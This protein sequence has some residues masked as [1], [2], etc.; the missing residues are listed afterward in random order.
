MKFDYDNV[1]ITGSNGWLGKKLIE[2]FFIE[3]SECIVFKKKDSLKVNC[4]I[5]PDESDNFI[6]S[7]SK[8]IR[9][10]AGDI[11]NKDDCYDFLEASTGDNI[12]IHAAG[13]IHPKKV[14][15]FFKVNL[16]G[17]KN[18][19]NEALN[20]KFKKIIVVSSNS[21][22]GCNKNNTESFNEKSPYNPYMN[23]GKS[24]MLMENFLNKKI[25]DGHDITI[26]RPPWFYG[27]NMPERQITFYNM[28]IS[29]KFPFVGDGKNVRSI[30]NVKN[31]VQ[32]IILSAIINKSKGQTYWIADK[33]NLSMNQIVKT[34]QEV[35][36]NEFDIKCKKNN[37]YLPHFVGQIAELIDYTL[38]KLGLYH[39]KFHVLS[40]MNK[41]IACDIKKAE[42]EL[43][44]MPKISLYQGTKIAYEKYLKSNGS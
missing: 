40:E 39:Q 11:V 21:P 42:D 9:V 31:I 23:Y 30:A 14:Q 2:S 27:E 41:N 1:Y 25:L 15:D 28:I 8:D 29:G 16:E 38:Q 43:G 24:K 17:T 32:G 12:L 13:L 18:I 37:I 34:I 33:D 44:Y 5:T 35:F 19:V 26:I 22:C 10:L 3:D 6:K 7:I 4:L 36:T 20:K